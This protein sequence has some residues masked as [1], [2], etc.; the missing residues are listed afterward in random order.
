MGAEI[1]EKGIGT[2]THCNND[3]QWQMLW[4]RPHN[5]SSTVSFWA[6]LV[7]PVT[8]VTFMLTTRPAILLCR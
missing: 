4:Y 6:F 1:I 3:A 2:D 5:K 7:F 8:L